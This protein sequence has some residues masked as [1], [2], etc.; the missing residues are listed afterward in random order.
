MKIIENDLQGLEWPG[1]AANSSPAL[2]ALTTFLP[3]LLT[4]QTYTT[5]LSSFDIL[6]S[7]YLHMLFPLLE[8]LSHSFPLP[9]VYSY[10]SFKLSSEA[11]FQENPPSILPKTISL[12]FVLF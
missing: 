4:I 3:S 5:S 10:S 8:F 12:C 9:Q 6:T 2:S 7:G 11:S 1:H